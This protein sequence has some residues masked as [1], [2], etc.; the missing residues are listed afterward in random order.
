MLEHAELLDPQTRATLLTQRAYSLYV[1]NEYEAALP[2]AVSAV[3]IAEVSQDPV[4]LTEA[5]ITLSRIAFFA[6]GPTMAREAALRAVQILETLAM[7][8]DSPPP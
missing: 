5:L 3:D 7:M 8:P 6:H 4:V 2:C 1:V